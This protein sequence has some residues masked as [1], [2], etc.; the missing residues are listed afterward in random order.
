MPYLIKKVGNKFQLYN[1]TKKVLVKTKYKTKQTAI[2]AG[3]NFMR[4]R[5]EKGIVKGININV[6]K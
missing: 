2:N 3:L 5:G 4:F 6:K 1:K